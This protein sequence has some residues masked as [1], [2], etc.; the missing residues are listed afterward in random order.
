M[1]ILSEQTTDMPGIPPVCTVRQVLVNEGEWVYQG[2][3]V[4]VLYSPFIEQAIAVQQR[5][6]D[7]EKKKLNELEDRMAQVESLPLAA[8]MLDELKKAEEVQKQVVELN[9]RV[10]QLLEMLKAA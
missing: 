7:V 10:K 4:A 1:S 3:T 2:E 6:I 5:R 8:V 9:I